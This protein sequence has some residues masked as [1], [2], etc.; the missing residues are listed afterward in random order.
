[1]HDERGREKKMADN[2]NQYSIPIPRQ[3]ERAYR[4]R[5]GLYAQAQPGRHSIPREVRPRRR[6]QDPRA[7]D[8]F[9]RGARKCGLVAGKAAPGMGNAAPLGVESAYTEP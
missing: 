1:V 2:T 9:L 7:R 5:E 4:G 8:M 6:T 3:R